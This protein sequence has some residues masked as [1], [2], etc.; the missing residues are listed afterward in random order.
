MIKKLILLV[1]LSLT[2]VSQIVSADGETPLRH[3]AE[4]SLWDD[5]KI[6]P[7]GKYLAGLALEG[8][9]WGDQKLVIIDT[10]TR[11]YLHEINMTGRAFVG[12]FMWANDNRLIAWEATNYGFFEQPFGTGNIIAVNADGTQKEW[13]YG[14]GKQSKT[15]FSRFSTRT[16]ARV[17]HRLPK[18][19]KHV[20]M[21]VRTGG[22]KD[23]QF[24][25]LVKL[26]I[27]TGREQ[28]IGSSPI[29]NASLMVDGEGALRFSFGYDIDDDEAWKVFER[30]G[31]KW[32]LIS[33]SEEYA[34]TFRPE[35]FNNENDKLWVLDNNDTDKQALYLYDIASKTKTLIYKHPTVDIRSVMMDEDPDTETGIAAGVWIMPDYPQYVPLSSTSPLNK[36]F[37]AIQ[38]QFPDHAVSIRS[39]TSAKDLEEELAVLEIWSDKHPG[40]YLLYNKTDSSLSKIEQAHAYID[41]NKMRPMEPYKLSMRDGKI[42]YAYLTRP[43]DSDGPFPLI[44]HPHGGPYGPRDRW[45]FNSEVQALASRGYAVLQVNFRGSGGY[46]KDFIY[47]AFRQWGDEMQDDLTDA[48]AWAI[49][50]GIAEPGKICIYGAS[51]GGYAA[52][53]GAVKE[54]DLYACTAVYVGVTDLQ[55]MTKKGDIQRRDEGIKYVR[56]AICADAAE[57][58]KDSPITYIDRLKADVMILHGTEDQRVPLA[59]AEILMRELDRLNKPYE[60]LIKQKEGHGFANVD[61]R[62]ESLKRLVSFF[63]RNIGP[64][65]GSSN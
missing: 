40:M 51:Y 13:V 10:K 5:I 4:Y 12:E 6:S 24:T 19:D 58:I 65:P 61:N 16:S 28:H 33:R 46:G 55:L 22:G 44:V 62:E 7:T 37:M 48:T 63:D 27:Y 54:P 53:M 36:W 59:H 3:F 17:T 8:D 30:V 35:A 26:N 60:T 20:L 2:L 34:G 15:Q 45:G 50:S 41:P 64:Q 14:S 47:S 38:K 39:E 49:K 43:D 57:C 11:E 1:A 32:E 56:K 52:L 31:Q 9:G 25:R 23:G 42:V 18:D 21:E 29:R